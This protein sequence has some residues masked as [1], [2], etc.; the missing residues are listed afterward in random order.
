MERAEIVAVVQEF[1]KNEVDHADV[2]Q[3]DTDLIEA[4]VLDSLLM[5]MLIGHCEERLDIELDPED[6]TEDNFRS[7]SSIVDFISSQA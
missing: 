1:F 3:D 6:L 2:V 5:V 7:L 4:G